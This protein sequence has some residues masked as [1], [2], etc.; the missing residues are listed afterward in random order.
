MNICIVEDHK[1]L[2]ENLRLLLQGEPDIHVSG[3]FESAEEA[4]T[5]TDWERTDILLADIELPG[6]SGVELIQ[7]V[8][9]AHPSV[10]AMA[11]TISEDRAVVMAAIRAGASGYLL[12]GSTPRILI[13]SVRELHEGGAPMSPKIARKLIAEL[14]LQD[15]AH[16]A[17][18]PRIELTQRETDVVRLVEKGLSYGEISE[19]LHISTHTVHSHIKHIYEKVHAS[20]RSE[21]LVKARKLGVI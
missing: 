2:L 7:R 4:V 16:A 9:H 20:S 6:M 19:A 8:K 17:G 14:R 1:M 11:Y 13:E 15:E 10:D 21:M 5:G 18:A 12:K 3:A